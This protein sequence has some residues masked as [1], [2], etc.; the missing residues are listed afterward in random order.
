MIQNSINYG[1]RFRVN[2]LRGFTATGGTTAFTTL[3]LK[4]IAM[5]FGDLHTYIE[6][7]DVRIPTPTFN[8]AQAKSI[9]GTSI[10][11]LV[12]SCNLSFSSNAPPTQT[13]MSQYLWQGV[14][15]Y[16]LFNALAWMTGKKVLGVGASPFVDANVSAV[17]P[18]ANFASGFGPLNGRLGR[19]WLSLQ[20]PYG[21]GTAASGPQ[22]WS[23]T[24][25][26]RFPVGTRYGFPFESNVIP[27][28]YFTGDYCGCGDKQPN[29]SIEIMLGDKVDGQ[30]VSYAGDGFDLDVN[31][32]LLPEDAPQIPTI[33]SIKTFN[34]VDNSAIVLQRGERALFSFT[35][36]LTSGG[37]E[38]S[39]TYTQVT[40]QVNGVDMIPQLVTDNDK[41]LAASAN[42][43]SPHGGLD[44]TFPILPFSTITGPAPQRYTTPGHIVMAHHGDPRYAPSSWETP[45]YV[46]VEDGDVTHWGIDAVWIP[47]TNEYCVAAAQKAGAA[48]KVPVPRN[49]AGNPVHAMQGP[50]FP[51]KLLP[52]SGGSPLTHK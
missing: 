21:A 9:D 44:D 18:A 6:S 40:A 12:K 45:T 33:M 22:S 5:K 2:L 38:Q 51:R 20:G 3:A 49:A 10:A 13:G 28:E 50:L 11:Q 14:D 16:R 34:G 29:G 25:T 43:D 19:G 24:V 41:L 30:N 48:G 42:D 37:A 52:P 8:V 36:P 35:K 39:N 32:V 4:D 46:K 1:R 17:E 7:I 31:L 27:A 26:F 47:T 23:D 15:G